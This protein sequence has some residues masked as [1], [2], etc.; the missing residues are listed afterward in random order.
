MILSFT[1]PRGVV[2]AR[3]TALLGRE[4]NQVA[5]EKYTEQLGEAHEAAMRGAEWSWR[6][7]EELVHKMAALLAG[8]CIL[9]GG[10]EGGSE[11]IRKGDA[12]RGRVQLP[13]FETPA[14]APGVSRICYVPHS[15]D[16][17]VYS[18]SQRGVA[19]VQLR[20]SGIEGLKMAALLLASNV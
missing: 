5:T 14:P 11:Y 12:F 19:K 4:A 9:I 17:L 2:G 8:L 20:H 16:W 18:V 6:E 13:F 7:D 3:R 15:D 10:R 1:L